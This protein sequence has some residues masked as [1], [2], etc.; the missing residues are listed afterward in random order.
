MP[1]RLISTLA[2]FTTMSRTNLYSFTSHVSGIM[3]SGFT[4]QALWRRWTLIAARMTARVCMRAIS[5]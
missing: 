5:G 1:E 3:I 2:V 4:L